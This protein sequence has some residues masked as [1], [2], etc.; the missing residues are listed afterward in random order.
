MTSSRFEVFLNSLSSLCYTKVHVLY[1]ASCI[2][3]IKGHETVLDIEFAKKMTHQI[4][5]WCK[6]VNGGIE[7]KKA[8]MFCD[9]Q[10]LLKIKK[11]SKFK[12]LINILKF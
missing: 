7:W 12:T 2:I 4:T 9:A 1:W 3:T 6:H 11:M 5:V 10:K 8:G